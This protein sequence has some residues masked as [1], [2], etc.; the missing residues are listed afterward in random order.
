MWNKRFNLVIY[1]LL[2]L[3]LARWKPFAPC[4]ISS[5]SKTESA[6]VTV[7]KCNGQLGKAL[8]SV[9]HCS[10]YYNILLALI[11]DMVGSSSLVPEGLYKVLWYIDFSWVKCVL[12][13]WHFKVLSKFK[14]CKEILSRIE[15]RV[16]GRS[17]SEVSDERT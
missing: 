16:R 8:S 11:R 7:V 6:N 4:D 15:L 14:V 2:P 12:S 13:L 5:E 10:F 3:Y 9:Y 1:C 17:Y